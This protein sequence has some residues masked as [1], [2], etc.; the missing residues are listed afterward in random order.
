MPRSTKL[1]TGLSPR[2]RCTGSYNRRGGL[3]GASPRARARADQELNETRSEPERLLVA[4][5]CDSER[6][7]RRRRSPYGWPAYHSEARVS[8]VPAGE[9][10]PG[11]PL[12][13][14][15]Q[16]SPGGGAVEG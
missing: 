5:A 3:A 7:D 4:Y 9:A 12:E 15:D 13:L 11:E 14:R 10:S 8:I 1:A 2:L 16:G 6:G